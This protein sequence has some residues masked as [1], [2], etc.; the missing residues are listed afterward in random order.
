MFEEVLTRPCWLERIFGVCQL[1][2]F[3][4][5]T[6]VISRVNTCLKTIDSNRNNIKQVVLFE[7]E[8][9]EGRKK[10]Y[11]KLIVSSSSTDSMFEFTPRIYAASR[12]IL[13]LVPSAK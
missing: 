8:D 12:G 7:C 5:Q 4:T 6:F 2:A 9:K 11:N 13:I 1:F 10:E 3:C